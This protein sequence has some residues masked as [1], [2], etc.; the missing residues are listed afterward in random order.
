MTQKVQPQIESDDFDDAQIVE[1]ADEGLAPWVITFADLVP[2]LLV[3]FIL[4]FAI[5]TIEEKKWQKIKIHKI[6][7]N[8]EASIPSTLENFSTIFFLCIRN[9]RRDWN[10]IRVVVRGHHFQL[11]I[12][13]K[14]SSELIDDFEKGGRLDRG[15]IA[16]QLHEKGTKIEFADVKMKKH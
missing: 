15:M 3:F 10:R 2:L 1:G 12:N 8:H 9:K 7:F 5:G 16:L 6:R 14:L 13:G 4:L 11:W